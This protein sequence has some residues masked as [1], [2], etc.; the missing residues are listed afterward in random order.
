[1]HFVLAATMLLLPV[2]VPRSTD[3][4]AAYYREGLMERVAEN[5]GISPT[6]CMVASLG[7]VIGDTLTVERGKTRLH[8]LVV[9][10]AHPKDV[11]SI[12]E[13]GIVVELDFQSARKI[14]RVTAKQPIAP[15]DCP[16]RIHKPAL[17]PP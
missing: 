9:D 8:C 13:R 10:V 4:F 2:L 7:S 16:V 5:R 15:R 11:A 12:R 17:A 1:M 6:P 3:G 14:C